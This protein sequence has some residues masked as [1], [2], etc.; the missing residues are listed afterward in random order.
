MNA[1]LD[2]FETALLT[3]LREHVDQQPAVRSRFSRPRLLLA[4]AATVAAAAAMVVVV[5]GLGSNTA[6]SVQDGNSGTITVEVKRLED[7]DGLE[8]ELAKYGVDADITYVPQ[9]QECAPGRYTPVDRSLSG[10]GVTMGAELLQVTLPPGTV[11]DG[12]TFVM[13]VSGE[14]IPPSSSEPSQDGITDMGGFSG[15]TDFNVTAGPVQP[16]RAV[17]S[18]VG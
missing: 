7:A 11:R 2:S 4:A 10:M 12:E 9:G 1:Q 14:A 8:A 16:C 5:P 15:W 6:Y 17:P 13:A 3:R 18:T